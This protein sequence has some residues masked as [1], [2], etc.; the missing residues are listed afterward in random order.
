MRRSGQPTINDV[1]RIAGVSKKTV[2]RVINRSPL[3]HAETRARVE[4]VIGDLGYIPNP[5]ARALALRRNFLIGLVHDNP[6]A[7]TVMNVQHGLLA[8]LRGT[9]FELVVRPVDRAS[10]TMIEDL[11]HFLERQRLFGVLLMPP[12]SEDDGVA[13]LCAAIGCRYVRMGSAMLDAPAQMVASDDRTAVHE[14]AA[15]LVARGHRRIGFI[16]GPDGFRSAHER[17]AGFDDALAAAGLALPD[18]HVADGHY[19]FESGLAAAERLLDA[20]PRPTAI[21]AAN[22]EMAAGVVHAARR[23]GLVIPDDLSIIGFDDTPIAAHLWP[24]LTTVRWPSTAMAHAAAS[25][26]IAEDG[27]QPAHFPSTLIHRA[28]VAAPPSIPPPPGGGG[29]PKA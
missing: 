23:R 17:R 19:T 13:R 8:G 20:I 15:H 21:F 27:E 16:G 24:P 29:A 28:S 10:P 12:I 5:Q 9:E 22:D 11:R 1:A 6:N 18:D 14:A 7:Q 25:K 2:S 4:R 26:L 3:L